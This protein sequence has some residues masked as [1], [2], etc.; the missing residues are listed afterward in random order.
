M[1]LLSGNPQGKQPFNTGAALAK[2]R[3]FAFGLPQKN[4]AQLLI[5]ICPTHL[6]TFKPAGLN[7]KIVVRL[8]IKRL[9]R[10]PDHILRP[11]NLDSRAWKLH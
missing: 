8:R 4:K 7:M 6:L 2:A 10:F 5:K 1:S 11:D 3:A 9:E